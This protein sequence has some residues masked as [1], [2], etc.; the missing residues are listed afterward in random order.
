MQSN[1]S[2]EKKLVYD[3]TMCL[4]HSGL[5]RASSGNVS[6]RVQNSEL[7]AITPT[8]VRYDVL[9]MDDIVVC[10]LDG[11]LV[12]GKMNPSSEFRMHAAIYKAFPHICGVVHTHSPF[13]ITFAALGESIPMVSIEGLMVGSN[14]LP[15]TERFSIPGSQEV[16][17]S[18]LTYFMENPDLRGLILS[19]HGL[20]TIGEKLDSAM[21]LAESIELE[22]Q[23]YY[24]TRMIGTPK[25]I[26]EEQ[27]KI[28]IET[29][30]KG[31]L[32]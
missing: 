10:D 5:I 25:L 8:G 24:Q 20:L 15:V 17:E 28:I 6:S 16:G 26:S 19:N 21:S 9:K 27:R 23:I 4:Y 12:E 1:Y 32:K 13:A 31:K 29:Y 2:E 7:M 14:I 22:A 3:T 11:V 18:A 30:M